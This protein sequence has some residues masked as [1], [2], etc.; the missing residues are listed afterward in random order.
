MIHDDVCGRL[1]GIDQYAVP[2][3]ACATSRRARAVRS[4]LRGGQPL[5]DVSDAENAGNEIVNHSFTHPNIT[6]G[7]RRSSGH[8]EGASST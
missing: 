7:T 4:G 5:E 8:V 1:R 6:L 3:L 2:A